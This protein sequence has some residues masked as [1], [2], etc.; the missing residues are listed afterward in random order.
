MASASESD[1]VEKWPLERLKAHPENAAIF[2]S[3]DEGGETFQTLLASIR[4]NGIWEPLI[5][6]PDGTILAGHL[7]WACAEKLELPEVPVR[8]WK[9]TSRREELVLLIRSNTDRRHLTKREIG[10]AQKKLK[11]TPPEEGGVARAPGRPKKEEENSAK[12]S[13]VSQSRDDAAAQLGVS[14]NIAEAC[15]TVFTTPGVPD[16]VKNAVNEER[17]G[18]TVAAN[19]VRAEV[20]RQGGKLKSGEPLVAK[21]DPKEW[22][23]RPEHVKR[24][25]A[26]A[27]RF[28]DDCDGLL[29][30]YGDLDRILKRR[31][32]ATLLGPT[33]HEEYRG[34]I[35]QIGDRV[36]LELEGGDENP[37]GPLTV[38][39]GGKE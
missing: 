2:E 36:Y 29:K 28:H 37:K 16:E 14:R 18:V 33:D 25:Q 22:D 4:E 20:K 7:R 10:L 12:F 34:L 23:K 32:L 13:W 9:V 11:E 39:E 21:L 35:E 26:E 27:D 6:K 30:V 31:P 5:V 24:L 1:K 38:I 17:L 3:P 15:V 19:A 8:V